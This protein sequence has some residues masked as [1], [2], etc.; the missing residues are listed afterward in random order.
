[1]RHLL[2]SITI[3]LLL[4]TNPGF[5]RP[6][7]HMPPHH[8]PPDSIGPS[9]PAVVEASNQFGYRF[10]N[11]ASTH[12]PNKNLFIS[13]VSLWLALSMTAEGADGKT[14]E[15]LDEA[16]GLPDEWTLHTA[17]RA[18]ATMIRHPR[19][20]YTLA[21]ANAVWPAKGNELRPE[22]LK[23]I[24]DIYFGESTPLAYTKDA[25]TARQTINHWVA[26][27]TE[28]RIPELLSRGA[29][30]ASTQI[31]LTNAIYFKS[32]WKWAFDKARTKDQPF[33]TADGNPVT[34]PMMN[35]PLGQQKFAYTDQADYKAIKIPYQGDEV[36]MTIILP[37][38]GKMQSVQDQ[39]GQGLHYTLRQQW[40]MVSL[41]ISIPRFKLDLGGS[42]R[43]VL[44]GM[45]LGVLFQSADMS[46]MFQKPQS[47]AISDVIHKAF[48]A[49][50]EAGTE[51]AAATAVVLSRS[52]SSSTTPLNFRADRPFLFMITH[53]STDMVLFLGKVMNPK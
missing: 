7:P 40:R 13:P 52:I 38:P 46:R 31:V 49:V 51:A 42:V 34:V 24:R 32:K 39:L 21:M 8:T 37:A 9:W 23:I 28:R 27:R 4:L 29:I 43:P 12:A 18:L 3:L 36:E 35:L 16:L 48:V 6:T 15:L 50:D 22:F 41:D 1:M 25:E 5:S 53:K 44:T 47:V 2:P 11:G 33:Y 20:P 45:G 19:A 17:L 10:L 30:D 26:S 14:L